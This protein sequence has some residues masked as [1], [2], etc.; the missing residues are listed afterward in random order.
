MEEFQ[1]RIIVQYL[2]II[3]S[4]LTNCNSQAEDH[5]SVEFQ[6]TF[7]NTHMKVYTVLCMLISCGLHFSFYHV[8][9]ALII[10]LVKLHKKNCTGSLLYSS[11]W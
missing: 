9:D 7:I 8:T 11:I 5:I 2:R 1:N 3:N 10:Q 6:L 4:S